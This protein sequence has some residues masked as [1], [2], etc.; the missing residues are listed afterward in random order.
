MVYFLTSKSL[1]SSAVSSYLN[2][3]MI[4]NFTLVIN[5]G[6]QGVGKVWNVQTLIKSESLL[7]Q[8]VIGLNNE[9]TFEWNA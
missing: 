4:Q 5:V 8:T 1:Q 6:Q 3:G 2:K 7:N 9:T